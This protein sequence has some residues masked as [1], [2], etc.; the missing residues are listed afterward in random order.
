[1]KSRSLFRISPLCLVTTGLFTLHPG[2]ISTA[3][4]ESFWNPG[5][6]GG[7]GNWGTSP[8]EK[9]WNAA[10]GGLPAGNTF[11]QDGIDELAVFQDGVGGIVTVIDTVQTTGIRHSGAGYT[12]N[13]GTIVLTTGSAAERPFVDVLSGSLTIDSLLDGSA[14]LLKTGAGNL[15]LTRDNTFTGLTTVEAGRL[16]IESALASQEV[17]IGSGAELVNQGG[18]FDGMTQLEN[19]G[20]LTLGANDTIAS[21][22]SNGG[23]LTAGATTLFTTTARLNDGSSVA[24]S[25][26]TSTLASSGLVNVSGTIAAGSATIESGVLTLNGSLISDSVSILSGAVLLNQSGGL[27]DDLVLS[28]S[29]RMTLSADEGITTYLSNGGTL[30]SAGNWLSAGQ[31]ELN[32]GSLVSGLLRSGSIT[33]DGTVSVTGQVESE[34]IDLRSGV[35]T[36]TG[37]LG[38]STGHLNIHSGA[39]LVAGGVQQYGLLTTSGNGTGTWLGNLSNSAT[40]APGGHGTT[41]TLRVEG[42]F[43]NLPGGILSL[44]AGTAGFDLLSVAGRATFGGTLQLHQLGAG[45]IEA[46]VPVQLIQAGSYSGNF[47]HMT[48]DL[49]GIVFFNPANGS[50]TRFE[51]AGSASLLSHATA[52]QASTWAALY[53]DVIDPGTR[54]VFRLPG[55]VPPFAVTSGIASPDDP[56]L[57]WA[58][59]ASITPE[60]MDAGLLNRLSPEVYAGL[61][62]YALQATRTHRRS[63]FQAPAL[64]GGEVAP[65]ATGSKDAKGFS[66]APAAASNRWEFF[67]AADYFDGETTGS[68][69]S[70]DYSLT[71]SGVVAGARMVFGDR[72]RIA[73]YLAGDDGEVSGN[74]I[75]GDGVGAVTGLLGELTLDKSHALRLTGG[76]SY[77]SY[78]FDGTRGGASATA[79]GW[80]PGFVGFDD[81]DSEALDLFVGLDAVAWRNERFLLIPAIGLN[82]TS[83]STDAFREFGGAATGS[84]IALAVD[85]SRQESFVSEFSLAAQAKV[86]EAFMVDGQAGFN[87]GFN[88]D[89]ERISA[90]FGAGGRPLAATATPLADDMFYMGL[91]ATWTATEDIR[92][93]LGYRAEFR[94]D[95]ETLNA[96]NLGATFGF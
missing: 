57:L 49:D 21:Y 44:D 30:E 56:D 45:E 94:S 42:D 43:A 76:I 89:P 83:A 24:G 47:A 86:T 78:T 29:G 84:P 28:N 62:D 15:V 8:G 20:T 96:L 75:D 92:I 25:L 85:R 54:N 19:S 46:M 22:L 82:Y 95:A 80:A 12:I 93:R 73:A 23:T 88:E 39:T 59:N 53:D 72:A 14:G 38:S 11:W 58:L 48:E 71:G 51:L 6:T 41:G 17:V 68:L 74:L 50:I 37:M 67:A 60:G 63:A 32:H 34:M 31:S 27:S 79:S 64:A 35:L 61:S 9:N 3:A 7:D 16:V 70:A 90:R 77:G 13:A 69:D 81:V 40:V 2:G 55:Q 36:N 87:M 66:L 5:G 4:T 10:P 26:D 52:N 33:T 65:V 18:G 91:G 1:M